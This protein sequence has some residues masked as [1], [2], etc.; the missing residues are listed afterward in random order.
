[1]PDHRK[2]TPAIPESPS[3]MSQSLRSVGRREGEEFRDG[4]QARLRV[5]V[6]RY[7][8]ASFACGTT[9]LVYRAEARSRTEQARLRIAV[10]RYGA[11]SFACI[12]ERRMV[13]QTGIEPV[14]S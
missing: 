13:D 6:R 14:T 1:M 8:A 4:V 11:A 3:R 5:A 9:W 12:H 10:R 7:G 2:K